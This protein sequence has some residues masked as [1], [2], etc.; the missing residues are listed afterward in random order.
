MIE[1]LPTTLVSPVSPNGVT[2][3]KAEVSSATVTEEERTVKIGESPSNEDRKEMDDVEENRSP[4]DPLGKG[5]ELS[6][7]EKSDAMI[8]DQRNEMASEGNSHT[9][10]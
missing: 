8:V 2:S 7:E 6:G 10:S 5:I 9:C 1:K 4:P 3:T